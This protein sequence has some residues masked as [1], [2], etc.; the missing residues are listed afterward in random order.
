MSLKVLPLRVGPA[1]V[2]EEGVLHEISEQ[3]LREALVGREPVPEPGRGVDHRRALELDG[4]AL[5]TCPIK[6]IY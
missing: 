1:D 4:A 3:H 6:S 5:P 2:F